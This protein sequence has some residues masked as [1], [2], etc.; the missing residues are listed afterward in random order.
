MVPMMPKPFGQQYQISA[1]KVHYAMHDAAVNV[2]G[3]EEDYQ[4]RNTRTHRRTQPT[5][6]RETGAKEVISLQRA[7]KFSILSQEG[8]KE[9][10][11]F[12]RVLPLVLPCFIDWTGVTL[13][14]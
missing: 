6:L 14:A 3:S 9:G 5:S 13:H 12:L 10:R 1:L 7:T 4:K 8:R 11:Y 2:E